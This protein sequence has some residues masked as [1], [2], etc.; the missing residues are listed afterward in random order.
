MSV[1]VLYCQFIEVGTKFYRIPFSLLSWFSGGQ[2]RVPCPAPKCYLLANLGCQA[3]DPSVFAWSLSSNS[4]SPGP[5]TSALWQ[6]VPAILQ[7]MGHWGQRWSESGYSFSSWVQVFL[8]VFW[9]SF[10]VSSQLLVL[11]ACSKSPTLGDRCTGSNLSY[12]PSP[13]PVTC[14]RLISVTKAYSMSLAMVLLLYMS[15]MS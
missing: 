1:V 12:A 6:R 3:T 4:L 7:Q 13:A 5:D 9:F 15:S 2:Y 11:L 8:A 10:S 14:R